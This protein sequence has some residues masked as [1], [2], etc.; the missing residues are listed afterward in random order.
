MIDII[1]VEISE[2]NLP[3]RDIKNLWLTRKVPGM[4]I[5]RFD[6]LCT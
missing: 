3:Q 2:E 1:I 4:T 5:Q 6:R